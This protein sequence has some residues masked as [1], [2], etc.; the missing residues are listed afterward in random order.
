M[1]SPIARIPKRSVVVAGHRT[2]VSIEGPFWTALVAAADS[3]GLSINALVEEIEAWAHD[4]PEAANL[5]S[6]IRL[7]L[8][9]AAQAAVRDGGKWFGDSSK[10]PEAK[11]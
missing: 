6:A 5:C 11:P 8:F 10:L 2:S 7:W 1:P 9:D 3:R 4:R